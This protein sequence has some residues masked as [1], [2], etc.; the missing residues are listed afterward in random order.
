MFALV[1]LLAS[2]GQFGDEYYGSGG[3]YDGVYGNF[4]RYSPMY[5]YRY[6]AQPDLY[7]INNGNRFIPGYPNLWL[8]SPLVRQPAYGPSFR[9]IFQGQYRTYFPRW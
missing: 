9:P 2:L 8:G 3:Y 6:F 5:G 7:S 4:N 1:L